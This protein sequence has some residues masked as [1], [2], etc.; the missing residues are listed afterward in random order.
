MTGGRTA[1]TSLAVAIICASVATHAVSVLNGIEPGVSTRATAE[2]VFG[3]P[4]RAVSATRFAYAA[5]GGASGIEI[6]YTAAQAVDRID[7]AFAEGLAR[8]D[9]IGALGLPVKADGSE[10]KDG[11]LFE[12]Y[13]GER[14]L[15]LT[16]AGSDSSSPISQVSYCSRAVFDALTAAVIKT[17]TAAPPSAAVQY[18]NAQD[19]PVI[20][21]F[22][23]NGCQDIY[24]WAQREHDNARR[25]RNAV[26]RQAI[27]DVMITAQKGDCRRAQELS[28][29]YKK[30]YGVGQ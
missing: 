3:A 16:H 8:E 12:Y 23:P 2:K 25:G 4:T 21:Q 11:R 6:E 20:I 26:R 27:L 1:A 17:D 30:A 14:T 18:S 28:E 22:N 9:A 5:A 13:A 29:A 15:V 19:K 24:Q 7:L 10:T